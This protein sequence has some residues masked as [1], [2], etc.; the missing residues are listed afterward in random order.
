[1]RVPPGPSEKIERKRKEGK[2]WNGVGKVKDRP[3]RLL[4][5]LWGLC[6]GMTRRRMEGKERTAEQAQA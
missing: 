4:A 3:S 2:G 6:K 1:M 5:T